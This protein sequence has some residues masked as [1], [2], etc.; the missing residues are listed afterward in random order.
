MHSWNPEKKIISH[1]RHPDDDHGDDHRTEFNSKRAC[2]H[3]TLELTASFSY[4]CSRGK[5]SFFSLKG[6][7]RGVRVCVIIS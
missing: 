2:L 7:N 4:T 1:H 3:K 5:C 6:Y